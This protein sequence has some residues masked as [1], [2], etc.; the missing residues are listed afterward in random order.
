MKTLIVEDDFASRRIVQKILSPYGE[1]D[2]AVDGHEAIEAFRLA[3]DEGKQYDLICMDIMMPNMDGQEALT[4]IR[5]IEK[6]MGISS[7]DEVKVIM[8]T[9]LDDP[10][11]V[12]SS[13]K[14]G[15]TSY[16][17]KPVSKQALLEE[18]RKL[19][20]FA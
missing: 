14:D 19:G 16:I 3:A 18:V 4:E 11:N 8:T 20:L 12:V 13:L 5:R 2:M 6:E 1:C 7:K 9:A 10:K 15:A 17:V